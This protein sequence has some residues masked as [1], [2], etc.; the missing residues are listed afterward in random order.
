[1]TSPSPSSP[2]GLEPGKKTD[3][4]V[5]E[6]IARTGDVRII[7]YFEEDLA[8]T[9]TYQQDMITYGAS[10]EDER[11]F[12]EIIAFM[13]FQRRMSPC[14]DDALTTVPLIVTIVSVDEVDGGLPVIKGILPF[15][16][17]MDLS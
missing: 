3:I 10:S 1:M 13:S 8:R 15:L 5:L 2:A 16:D 14:F 4:R 7:L 17:E 6:A 9:S 12:I 11:P